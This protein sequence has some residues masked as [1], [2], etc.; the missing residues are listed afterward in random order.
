[1]LAW[2]PLGALSMWIVLTGQLKPVALLKAGHVD[3]A[4]A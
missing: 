3:H 1:M 4:V 2:I